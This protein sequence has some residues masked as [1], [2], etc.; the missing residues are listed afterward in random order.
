M[1]NY[2]Q[3]V[4]KLSLFFKDLMRKRVE[5]SY[6]SLDEFFGQKKTSTYNSLFKNGDLIHIKN[7]YIAHLEGDNERLYVSDDSIIATGDKWRDVEN[8][9]WEVPLFNYQ[10]SSFSKLKY[11]QIPNR[12]EMK[13]QSLSQ[14]DT[15]EVLRKSTAQG[16]E[17]SEKREFAGSLGLITIICNLEKKR[18]WCTNCDR[19][20]YYEFYAFPVWDFAIYDN[21]Q[22][23]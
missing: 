2:K 16:L 22:E 4:K 3:H 9:V 17:I 23:I 1:P 14:V 8:G 13:M 10:P 7:V 6:E 11:L 19:T 15:I 20:Y 12:L 5:Y 18:K 21:K